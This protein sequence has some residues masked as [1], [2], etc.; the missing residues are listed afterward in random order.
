[1]RTSLKESAKLFGN[2]LSS[3]VA[4]LLL[5]ALSGVLVSISSLFLLSP[6]EK[7]VAFNVANEATSVKATATEP[8]FGGVYQ[9]FLDGYNYRTKSVPSDYVASMQKAFSDVVTV[10]TYHEVYVDFGGGQ[11]QSITLV[12]TTTEKD[13]NIRECVLY[14]DIEL[15]GDSAVSYYPS[16][17]EVFVSSAWADAWLEDKGLGEDYSAIIGERLTLASKN[18][19]ANITSLDFVVSGVFFDAQESLAGA[20]KVFGEF[21][22]V[23]SE[24]NYP[25]LSRTFFTMPQYD[26]RLLNY[27]T[28]VHSVFPNGSSANGV[29][30]VG[31][32]QWNDGKYQFEDS[33][34]TKYAR[35]AYDAAAVLIQVYFIVFSALL[36]LASGSLILFASFKRPLSDIYQNR[37]RN[38]LC[39]S[40]TFI[41]GEL[42]VIGLVGVFNIRNAFIELAQPRLITSTNILVTLVASILFLIGFALAYFLSASIKRKKLGLKSNIQRQD[43]RS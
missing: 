7:N 12:S 2:Y 38:L 40:L 11:S 15:L 4:Y 26:F 32:Y 8:I 6:N 1:M 33:Y 30:R 13:D 37:K 20:K 25:F 28:K 24:F 16:D 3:H 41:L 35:A 34:L 27:L 21:F 19:G 14:P 39:F 18:R 22:L 10:K 5:A 17:H 29:Y 42:V 23:R 43:N 9:Q 31:F 36:Y